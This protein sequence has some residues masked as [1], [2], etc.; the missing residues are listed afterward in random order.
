MLKHHIRGSDP[1]ASREFHLAE[2]LRVSKS[3][4]TVTRHVLG[5]VL[6]HIRSFSIRIAA[7][8]GVRVLT[9]TFYTVTRA[10]THT[11]LRCRA[12]GWSAFI[13]HVRSFMVRGLLLG[14][15]SRT[16]AVLLLHR[17]G[18]VLIRLI[19]IAREFPPLTRGPRSRSCNK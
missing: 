18:H 15:R 2:F 12:I 8:E 5:T 10:R 17:T 11:T 13:R 1:H 19:G 4:V 16:K 14:N 9:M 6:G 7:T 3:I